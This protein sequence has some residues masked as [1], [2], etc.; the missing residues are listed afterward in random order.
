MSGFLERVYEIARRRASQGDVWG[1]ICAVTYADTITLNQ[2]MTGAE[3]VSIDGRLV[4][5]RPVPKTTS[6]QSLVEAM[7]QVLIAA[8]PEEHRERVSSLFPE[9]DFLADHETPPSTKAQN[10]SLRKRT[11]GLKPHAFK[12][13]KV[14]DSRVHARA[15]INMSKAGVDDVDVHAAIRASDV[16]VFESTSIEYSL[17]HADWQLEGHSIRMELADEM[18]RIIDPGDDKDILRR[19]LKEQFEG[20]DFT[21]EIEWIIA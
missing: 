10:D 1:A 8:L 14:S 5:A 15:S 7:R 13:R 20:V 2:A 18:V 6:A 9:A 3:G 17:S 19:A 16:A 11:D 21:T 12:A 4:A